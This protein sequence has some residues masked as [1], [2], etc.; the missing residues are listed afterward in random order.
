M[1]TLQTLRWDNCFSYGSGN[2]LDLNDNTVTQ[3][4]GTNGMG[5]S[6]IPLIIEEALY[7]KNSK[8]IKKADIPNRHINDG[9]NI[10]LS[11]M[12]DEDRYE[13]TINRKTSIKVKLEKNGLDISSHTAT[14]TYK[15]IQ[16]IL[17]VDFKTFSQLVYQNTNAS[18]QFLT[19]TDA[20]R[21]KFLIDL[22][23][24][25]K[26]VELFELF[27]NATR[28]VSAVS[29][30]IDGKLTTVENWLQK[31]KL[32]DTSILPMLDLEID[33]SEDEKSLRSLTIEIEN[34][35]EK[36]K[37][38]SKNN[39]YKKLLEAIDIHKIQA[40]PIKEYESYDELQEELGKY[41]AVASGA[42][43]TIKK[44]EKL[45]DVCP[46]CGQ[47]IDIS[48]EKKMLQGERE[49]A[50]EA[51]EK[52]NEIRP[53][54]EEIKRNNREFERC[55]SDK[56]TWEDL[57]RL[58]DRDLPSS[59]LDLQE[60]RSRLEDV[61][62][63]LQSAKKKLAELAAENERRTHHNTRVQ[64]IQEQTK[65]FENQF[66]KYKTELQINQKLESNL[67]ILKK[68]F[69]TNGLLAYKIENLVGE[70][71]ELANEYLAELSDGRFT[72]EF[73]VSND[74]LN[75]Q[76]TDNGN[77]VDIL[78]LSSGELARVNTATLIAIR[79]LMSSISKSKINILFLDEVIN[80]LDDLGR[81]KLVEVLLREDLNTYI[82]SHGWSHPLLEKIEV[83]KHE[84]I[85]KLER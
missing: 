9:Y 77:V 74:K 10:Y 11:F 4:L 56:K 63:R 84:N 8:G 66:E 79:K 33:T 49:V 47:P 25:E 64:V 14:N 34:I 59:L 3:I 32:S 2:E 18:L 21:K 38:I 61:Q 20:N 27:K 39:Q 43:Q 48:L 67:D 37:K 44:L 80:V 62:R 83:V 46:T 29:S 75:V 36:N 55:E 1:I 22:L 30:T 17:G 65:D 41:N 71:E 35:S 45:S 7:N 5:K 78:A 53:R 26:Y 68:S 82:V 60:L 50:L 57:F 42:L 69:S 31:N 6:S 12:K 70:L 28:E 24:L 51:Q 19:A 52:A 58:Y 73:V 72:L 13:I 85:S 40:S 23:H 54:I 81:E 76:I 15:T 16:E